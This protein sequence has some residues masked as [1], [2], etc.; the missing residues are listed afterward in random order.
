MVLIK[1]HGAQCVPLTSAGGGEHFRAALSGQLHRSHA[2][3]TG[4]RV[5]QHQFPGTDR[6]QIHQP[7]QGRHKRHRHRR[8]MGG[9][10]PPRY[11]DQPLLVHHR[12]RTRPVD[13]SHYRVA[14]GHTS[15]LGTGLDDDPGTFCTQHRGLARVHIQR[16]QHIPEIDPGRGHC[17]P[18]LPRVQR[19]LCLRAGLDRKILERPAA[20]RQPPRRLVCR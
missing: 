17:Q 14:N 9:R 8:G 15:D 16:R 3:P 6:G 12:Q 20:S 5:H 18:N 4:S 2:Y 10:P 7:V 19:C 1:T 11:L 13:Q